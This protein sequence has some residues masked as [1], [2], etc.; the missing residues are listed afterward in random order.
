MEAIVRDRLTVFVGLSLMYRRS[1]TIRRG[2]DLSG[3]KASTPWRLGAVAG[4]AIADMC[5]NFVLS[6][7]QTEMYPATTM[8]RRIGS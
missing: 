2:P 8:S 4:R 7:G 1:S 6:S 5:P 3:L